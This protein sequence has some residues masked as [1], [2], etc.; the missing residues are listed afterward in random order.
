MPTTSDELQF[1]AITRIAGQDET[2][3]ADVVARVDGKKA[4]SVDAVTTISPR[5]SSYTYAAT[6]TAL[7]PASS[8]TDIFTI[9]GSSSKIVYVKKIVISYSSVSS[10]NT[11]AILIKRSSAN[12]G[13]TSTVRTAV[14]YY[15][16]NPAA[17]AT[18]RAYTA[19][20]TLGTSVGQVFSYKLFSTGGSN[21]LP[22]VTVITF[23]D[24]A[25]QPIVL[26]G[27][28]EVLAINLNGVTISSS[29]AN[30]TIEWIEV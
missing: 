8:A 22:Q 3:A 13:G 4:L 29:T 25:S 23:G 2:Y 1:T 17:T 12:S 28:S 27:T 20:P 11:N 7:S 21:V 15:S 14:P 18:V 24:N 6:V 16:T 9:T 19:N 5:S 26:S 30:I 10:T